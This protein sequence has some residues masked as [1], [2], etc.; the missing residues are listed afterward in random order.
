MAGYGILMIIFGIGIFTCGMYLAK[1][2][3]SELL[4]W[5]SNVK[6]MTIEE[7]KYSGKVTMATAIAPIISGIV[8]F[9]YED[10][11]VPVIILITSIILFLVIAIKIFK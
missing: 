5:R 2:H 11:I 8:A 4:L 1:G 6:N 10:S 9:F 7:V 3:K